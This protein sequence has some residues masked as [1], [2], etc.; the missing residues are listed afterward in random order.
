MLEA[1][2][3]QLLLARLNELPGVRVWR[4]N[5]GFARTAH[6]VVRFGL[7]PGSADLIGFCRGGRFLAIEVKSDTGRQTP[8]QLAFQCWVEAG[9]GVYILAR[10]LD[11]TIEAVSRL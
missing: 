6:G 3:Q 2:L 10:E 1:K 7:C 4:N 8:D 11:A 5:V 9:G